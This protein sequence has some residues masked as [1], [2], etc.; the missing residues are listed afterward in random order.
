M[1]VKVINEPAECPA[2]TAVA[3][4]LVENSLQRV[5][6]VGLIAHFAGVLLGLFRKPSAPKRLDPAPSRLRAAPNPVHAASNRVR[7]A[8]KRV[9]AATNRVHAATNP[10]RAASKRLRAARG[11][12]ATASAVA[13]VSPL[14]G[15]EVRHG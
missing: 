14:G 3:T 10:V 5:P 2:A 13:I 4:E 15:K 1:K 8:S 9:R 11:C 12:G 7:A 6:V